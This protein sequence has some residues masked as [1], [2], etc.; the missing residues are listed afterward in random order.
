MSE[1]KCEPNDYLTPRGKRIQDEKIVE[2]L[3][4]LIGTIHSLKVANEFLQASYEKK[5]AT[6]RWLLEKDYKLIRGMLDEYDARKED[7]SK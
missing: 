2:S 7:G 6:L 4:F 1:I 3:E 5:R